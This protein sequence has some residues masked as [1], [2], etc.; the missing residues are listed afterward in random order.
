MYSGRSLIP[1]PLRPP[2]APLRPG[3]LDI[4]IVKNRILPVLERA[5]VFLQVPTSR[6]RSAFFGEERRGD[7]W[8]VLRDDPRPR[9]RVAAVDPGI[10]EP[11]AL[12]EG[13]AHRDQPPL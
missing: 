13:C 1:P 11:A 10:M 4:R 5:L 8:A 6:H 12:S 3:R 9:P 2:G 7:P